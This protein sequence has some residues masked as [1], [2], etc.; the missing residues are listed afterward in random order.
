MLKPLPDQRNSHL[1]PI[2]SIPPSFAKSQKKIIF[3]PG[4]RP[5]QAKSDT[6]TEAAYNENL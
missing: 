3:P 4:R 2:S 1:K 5:R 6:P